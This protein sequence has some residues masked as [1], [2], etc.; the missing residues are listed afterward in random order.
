MFTK[1]NE[2]VGKFNSALKELRDSG[3][4]TELEYYWIKNPV[5]NP[6]VEPQKSTGKN[7]TVKVAARVDNEPMTYLN[8]EGEMMGYD[9]AVCNLICDKLDIK[10]EYVAASAE[11]LILSLS[12]EL[13]TSLV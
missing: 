10:A 3:K 4:L 8:G 11:S 5:E 12:S 2:Y 7:G 13:H 6:V 1:G 9:I